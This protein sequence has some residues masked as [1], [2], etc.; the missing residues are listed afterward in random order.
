MLSAS[1]DWSAEVEE[2]WAAAPGFVVS[3]KVTPTEHEIIRN[4]ERLRSIMAGSPP[5]SDSRSTLTVIAAIE[6]LYRY[7]GSSRSAILTLDLAVV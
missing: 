2:L 3:I 4:S 5:I 1:P 6:L 7:D